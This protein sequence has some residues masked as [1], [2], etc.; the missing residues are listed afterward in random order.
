[1]LRRSFAPLVLLALL[2][3]PAACKKVDEPDAP[4]RAPATSAT[5]S[6]SASGAKGMPSAG[7]VLKEDLVVGTGAEAKSG[8]NVKVHYTGTLVNG[9]KFDS[10][11]DRGEPYPF[12]ID[13]GM[14]IPGWDQGVKG[15]KVGGRRKLTIPPDLAYGAS[16]QGKI[17][18]NATLLFDIEL[19]EVQ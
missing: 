16:G 8:S 7:S 18:P 12:T 13:A 6:S 1:M 9:E 5:P 14:V 17:P 4:S 15:M 3:I 11:R 10:S 19:L 2:L